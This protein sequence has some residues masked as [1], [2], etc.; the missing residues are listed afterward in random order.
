MIGSLLGAIG[1]GFIWGVMVLGIFITYKIL[2][3]SDL[4]VDGSFATGGAVFAVSLLANIDTSICL[5]L[6]M[7]AGGLC[8][9]ITGLLHTKC[10]IPAILAGILT[11][12]GLYSINLRILGD[13]ANVSISQL[14][15]NITF[16]SKITN[17][18]HTRSGM[19]LGIVVSIICVLILYFLLGTEFGAS[20]RATGNNETMI[21]AL[22]VNTD[23]IKLFGIILSN[24]L[25]GLSGAMLVQMNKYADVGM[26]KGAIVYGLASIVIGEVFF[27]RFQN[28]GIKL[29]SSIFGCIVFFIIRAIVIRLGLKANDMQLISAVIVVIALAMPIFKENMAMRNIGKK[30][31]WNNYRKNKDVDEIVEDKMTRINVTESGGGEYA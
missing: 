12:L 3:V 1:Q 23:N 2:N 8:G 11:Q 7:I 16:I 26:G 22:G 19:V 20:I 24:M 25:I 10:K 9:L 4:T 28:F 5:L 27:R 18:T 21:R 17:L 29:I 14:S 30:N 31:N 6:A 15:T 13:K